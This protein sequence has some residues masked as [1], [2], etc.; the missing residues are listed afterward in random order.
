[1]FE[2]PNV[3]AAI[4]IIGVCFFF[5]M[6]IAAVLIDGAWV[7]GEMT[8]SELGDPSRPADAIFNAACIIT[9][10]LMALFAYGMR[11]QE[12]LPL[13]RW[14][15]FLMMIAGIFLI[16]I[17]V[18]PIHIDV[19]HT[20]FSWAFFLTMLTAILISVP[21]NWHRGRRGKAMSIVSIAIVATAVILLTLT[22][23]GLAEAMS[24]I[25]IMIWALMHGVDMLAAA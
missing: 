1:M 6:W 7:F 21:P 10:I 5:I 3:V 11:A 4:G 24:V 23:I 22:P 12:E 17:G 20:F 8:L 15:M 16:G 9:G 25:F 2:H 18:F 13:L 14:S 19:W